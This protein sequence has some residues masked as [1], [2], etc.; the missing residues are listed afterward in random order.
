VQL[1]LHVAVLL[2]QTNWHA[3]PVFC[4]VPVS[5]HVCGCCPL[6]WVAA[7]VHEPVR[8]PPL[9][10]YGQVDPLLVHEPD[11][12]HVCGWR[13]LHWVAAGVHE[14]V[15]APPTHAWFVHVTALPH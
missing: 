10:T 9:H 1:P 12:L 15:Q 2:L 5:S 4:H 8:V 7:G 13:P 6:H 3:V 11:A 14:P